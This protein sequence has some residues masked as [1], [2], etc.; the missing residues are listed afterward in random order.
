MWITLWKTEYNSLFSDNYKYVGLLQNGEKITSY[1]FTGTYANKFKAAGTAHNSC[2]VTDTEISIPA[3]Q[4]TCFFTVEIA[5]I[6]VNGSFDSVLNTT[7][8]TGT[9]RTYPVSGNIS[10]VTLDYYLQN[11][12]KMNM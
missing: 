3:G 4:Q 10:N 8:N 1:E 5:D 9:T 2:T 12:C 11:V 6:S 7:L